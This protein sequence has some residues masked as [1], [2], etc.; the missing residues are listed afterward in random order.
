[1]GTDLDRLHAVFNLQARGYQAD[2]QTG[3]TT[4]ACHLT[5]GLVETCPPGSTIIY[6]LR[7]KNHLR[8]VRAMLGRVL[9]EHELEFAWVRERELVVNGCLVRFVMESDLYDT[10]RQLS[11]DF[12]PGAYFVPNTL[13]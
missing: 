11:Y 2:R 4:L 1:M 9:A 12:V 10:P 3:K 13:E 6:L 8:H 7:Q 5:A